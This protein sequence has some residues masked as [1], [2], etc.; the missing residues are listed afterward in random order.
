MNIRDLWDNK[1]SP[2]QTRVRA[3]EELLGVQVVIN[4]DWDMLWLALENNFPD[5]EIFVPT[6]IGLIQILCQ[7]LNIKLEDEQNQTWTD[8]FLEE[9]T[10][11]RGLVI[12]IAV[13]C[14][15]ITPRNN[16]MLNFAVDMSRIKANSDMDKAYFLNEPRSAYWSQ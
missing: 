5:K 8:R 4:P 16:T 7:S 1:E 12:E 2:I 15:S 6:I 10:K 3:L 9:I 13:G 11:G 14:Q